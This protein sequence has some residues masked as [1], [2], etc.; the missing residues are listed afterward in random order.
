VLDTLGERQ[1]TAEMAMR[2]CISVGQASRAGPAALADRA[3]GLCASSL[4]G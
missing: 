1:T 2:L 3:R 4:P